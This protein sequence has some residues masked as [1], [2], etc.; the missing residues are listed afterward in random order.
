MQKRSVCEKTGV[1][2]KGDLTCKNTQI[3]WAG[4]IEINDWR[5]ATIALF[6][7]IFR[8]GTQHLE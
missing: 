2:M 7:N 6:D 4:K 3:G 5:R 1:G 8:I